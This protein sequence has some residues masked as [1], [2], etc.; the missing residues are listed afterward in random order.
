MEF[1]K[2]DKVRFT[3]NSA[4]QKSYMKK[5]DVGIIVDLV[6]SNIAILQ[7]L[8]DKKY[9]QICIDGLKLF[10]TKTLKE[11]IENGT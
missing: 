11:F 2:G 9:G 8:Q 5:G 3:R 7:R 10:K 4:E 6:D 1:K